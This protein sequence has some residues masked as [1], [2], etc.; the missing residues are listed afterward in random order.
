[1][2]VL[3]SMELLFWE[4]G[5]CVV[6]EPGEGCQG[7]VAPQASGRHRILLPPQFSPPPCPPGPCVP[8]LFLE[9]AAALIQAGRAQD[10]LTVCEE[11]LRRTSCLRPKMPRLSENVRKGTKGQPYCPLWVSATHLLEGQAWAKLEASKEAISDFS[12]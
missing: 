9:A 12:R 8:E 6:P 11:L 3:L 4:Q 7:L 2:S 5:C 10:A 1:M